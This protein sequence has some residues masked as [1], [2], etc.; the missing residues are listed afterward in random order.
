MA[1][2]CHFRNIPLFTSA[3]F[4]VSLNAT[5]IETVFWPGVWT[6]SIL[7]LLTDCCRQAYFRPG[8]CLDWLI[9]NKKYIRLISKEIGRGFPFMKIRTFNSC[10]TFTSKLYKWWVHPDLDQSRQWQIFTVQLTFDQE[11]VNWQIHNNTFPIFFLN[12]YSWQYPLY[13]AIPFVPLNVVLR[14]SG[15]I[16]TDSHTES[17]LTGAVSVGASV[18]RQNGEGDGGPR[19]LDQRHHLRVGQIPDGHPVDGHDG[20]PHVEEPAAGGRRVRDQ[21]AWRQN[22]F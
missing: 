13:T 9:H 19:V 12:L 7:I 16:N 20:V 4:L 6:K 14:V 10:H 18:G 5:V 17:V 15:H 1:E 22:R 2:E 11:R 21:L 3:L 8:S